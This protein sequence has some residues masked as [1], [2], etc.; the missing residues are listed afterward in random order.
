MTKPNKE[1][2]TRLYQSLSMPEIG[3]QY[4]VS[5]TSVHRWFKKYSIEVKAA[6]KHTNSEIAQRYVAGATIDELVEST[7]YTETHV[8]RKLQA[9]GIKLRPKQTLSDSIDRQYLYDLYYNQ[10]LSTSQI[11]PLL[12]CC[13][14]KVA[15]LLK[16]YGY[17]ARGYREA[18]LLRSDDISTQMLRQWESEDYRKLMSKGYASVKEKMAHLAANQLGRISDIQKVLHSLLDDLK[19]GGSRAGWG[20]TSSSPFLLIDLA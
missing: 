16:E 9:A 1:E 17:E 13:R 6:I 10:K 11:A 12:G 3:K 5:S 8:Y 19:M 2:L 15:H 20:A 7:G 4:G 14:Q 18:G